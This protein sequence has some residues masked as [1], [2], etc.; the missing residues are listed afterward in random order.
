MRWT[1]LLAVVLACRPGGA[2]DTP[3][4]TTDTDTVDSTKP[5]PTGDTGSY[6]TDTGKKV[7]KTKGPQPCDPSKTLSVSTV[8]VTQPW[9][10]QEAE[11]TVTLTED[12]S[13]AVACTL[14]GDAEEVHLVEGT[15]EQSSHTLRLS[16]LLASSTYDC[17]AATVCPEAGGGPPLE[18]SITTGALSNNKLAPISLNLK[19]DR[20]G[21]DYIV[22]NNQHDPWNGQRRM[23]IDRD[24]N[25]RWHALETAGNSLG[26]SA[27]SYF[28]ETGTFTIGGGWN[29]P[30][31]NRNNSGRPVEID[32]FGST[33]IFDTKDVVSDFGGRIFHH[34]AKKIYDGRL[35]G[36]TEPIIN[37][38]GGGTFFG[39]GIILVDPDTG[40]VEM[41]WSSQGAYDAGHLG[42]GGG[43]VYHANWADVIDQG[44]QDVAYVSLC[45]TD[46][47]VAIDV[48]SGN[49]R[50]RFG[51]NGD[52]TLKDKAGNTLGNN[53][54]PQCQ[55]GL[56]IKGDRLLVYDNGHQRGFSRAVEYILDETTMTATL[57]WE[58]TEDNWFER[59]VGG[60][61]WTTGDRVLIS[62][63]HL[64]SS[65]TPNDRTTF[66]EVDPSN[67]EKLW[68]IQYDN[69]PDF[70][71]RAEA[72]APCDIF[73]NA[74]Y[75][76]VTE[77]RLKT[78]D[79]I[80]YPAGK[81]SK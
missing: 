79:P 53:Q 30:R 22:T 28:P 49:W 40:N 25:I 62:M 32:L 72:I 64:L 50:W 27:V 78:L 26:G 47:V 67:G 12:A 35:L 16:G 13:L 24:G 46:S 76:A 4:D 44:G 42:G 6:I 57:E 56:Q 63:G 80:L 59:S 81:S 31:S 45:N 51:P 70:A 54:Y 1:V 66:V 33:T 23:V 5:E 52:F 71:F 11:V 43:D 69:R 29:A 60:V 18:F 48:P 73:A 19:K 2:N 14:D 3:D 65:P 15:E 37:A 10:E 34:E 8:D 68:E 75:C 7:I 74:K 39:F 41:D 17:V 36:M 77:A 61:D 38:S 58:W 21:K 20:A 55:H 9:N